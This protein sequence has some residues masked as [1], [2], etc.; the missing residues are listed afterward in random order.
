MSAIM[1]KK[2]MWK[3]YIE[4]YID[5]HMILFHTY[6]YSIV[7]YTHVVA[8]LH[9]QNVQSMQILQSLFIQ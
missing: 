5:W 9:A 3:M 2:E 7:S 1:P 6:I 8:A 4:L